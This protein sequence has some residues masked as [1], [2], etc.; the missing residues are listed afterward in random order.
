MET[1]PDSKSTASRHLRLLL[2]V[3]M[4]AL[5]R[6]LLAIK[7]H[8]G[9]TLQRLMANNIP[10]RDGFHVAYNIGAPKARMSTGRRASLSAGHLTPT[11]SEQLLLIALL[12]A[13]AALQRSIR[14]GLGALPVGK[15]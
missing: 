1:L 5:L 13:E 6:L 10:V 4:G 7:I 11:C 9:D 2:D 14:Q 12:L 15:V 8:G 3:A